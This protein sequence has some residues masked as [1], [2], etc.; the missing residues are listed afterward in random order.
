LFISRELRDF[1]IKGHSN[2]IKFCDCP[3]CENWTLYNLV[4]KEIKDFDFIPIFSYKSSWDFDKKYEY[5]E[6]FN[7]WRIIFQALDAKEQHFLELLSNDL[8]PIE[9]SYAK[10]EL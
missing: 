6:I 9:L 5:D 2:F 8:N 7:K 10:E 4:N 1:F 3:S